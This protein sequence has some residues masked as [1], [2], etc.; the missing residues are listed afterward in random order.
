MRT[1]FDFQ[2]TLFY[3]KGECQNPIKIIHQDT[4]YSFPGNGV[5]LVQFGE[6]ASY[7]YNNQHM[8]NENYRKAKTI[9]TNDFETTFDINQLY[10]Y[11]ED[12]FNHDPKYYTI[13][14]EKYKINM[15]EQGGFFKPHK[16]TPRSHEFVGT[17]IICLQNEFSGGNLH[18]K[19]QDTELEINLENKSSHTHQWVMFF[20]DI[21]HWIDEVKSGVRMTLTYNVYLKSKKS[22]LSYECFEKLFTK[23]IEENINEYKTTLNFDNDDDDDNDDNSEWGSEYDNNMERW[24][25]IP[26]QH[27]YIKKKNTN[28]NIKI[29]DL[30]G[31][32]MKIFEIFN[33]MGYKVKIGYYF[34]TSENLYPKNSEFKIMTE[35]TQPPNC[36]DDVDTFEDYV[37]GCDFYQNVIVLNKNNFTSELIDIVAAYGNEPTT[38]EIYESIMIMVKLT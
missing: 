22:E 31:I 28:N 1:H 3:V 17:I 36:L 30:K 16:D 5:D 29:K 20:G 6:V 24:L 7:G 32:D 38:A 25:A 4:L 15:Y 13:S 37:N 18:F 2:N 19:H 8:I 34:S 12:L 23:F 35:Y 9:H 27:L 21:T 10:S 14:I 33:H 11:A 26:S